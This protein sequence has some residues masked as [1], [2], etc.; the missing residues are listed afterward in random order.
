MSTPLL[1]LECD[2]QG[3]VCSQDSPSA[4]IRELFTSS[5]G[6]D[7]PSPPQKGKTKARATP[8][9]I[10][11]DRDSEEE[12]E[13]IEAPLGGAHKRTHK[14]QQHNL[15][16]HKLQEHKLQHLERIQE[17]D[18]EEDPEEDEEEDMGRA[19]VNLFEDEDDKD[20]E[21]VQERRVVK[22]QGKKA[23][24]G[25]VANVKRHDTEFEQLEM[26]GM[27]EFG[28]VTKCRNKIEYVLWLLSL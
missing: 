5:P 1:D 2:S 3:T 21:Q 23:W 25:Q 20:Q 15:Q 17:E 14:L 18:E 27:G 8:R 26:L 4:Q 9:R 22:R 10:D 7:P 13:A 16:E 11:W 12:E 6:R 19:L 24:E 28:V